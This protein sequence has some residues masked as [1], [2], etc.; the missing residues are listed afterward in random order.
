MTGRDLDTRRRPDGAALTI[1]AVLAGLGGLLI[2]EGG[3]IPEKGGY[4]G[5]GSG[6]LPVFVGAGLVLLGLV[7]AVQ[8]VRGKSRDRDVGATA[9]RHLAMPVLL[10]MAGL[11]LQLTLL[12]PL[13]FS[14]ATGLLFACTTA[15]FGKRNLA[16]TL[17]L[18][19]MFA[20]LVYSVFDGL[21]Q[22]KL[23]AGFPETL[24]FGS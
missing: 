20:L 14:I 7:H 18:G 2:W 12:K 4:A 9:E 5:I 21:L 8:G 15:A 11:F 24:I 6:D 16:L 1:A 10:I 3:R 23:P 13:G 22:L 19:F 17:P